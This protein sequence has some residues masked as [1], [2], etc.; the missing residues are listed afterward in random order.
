MVRALDFERALGTLPA[1]Q[2]AALVLTYRTGARRLEIARARATI[3]QHQRQAIA[4][5]AAQLVTSG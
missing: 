3:P 4:A 2:Q 5:A 1:A